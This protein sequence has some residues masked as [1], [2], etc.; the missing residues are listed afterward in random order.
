MKFSTFQAWS[1][2]LITSAAQGNIH[3]AGDGIQ[4]RKD[5]EV[6][7]Q[8]ENVVQVVFR[9]CYNLTSSLVANTAGA[10]L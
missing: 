1:L 7:M 6:T 3:S 2:L 10:T 9:I 4:I 5:P 8:K